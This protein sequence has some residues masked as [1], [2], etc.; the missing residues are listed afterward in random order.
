MNHNPYA[1]FYD[2]YQ[3]HYDHALKAIYLDAIQT[4]AKEGKILE[5]GCGPAFIG[6]ALA[7]LGYDVLATDIS[8]DFLSQAQKNATQAGCDLAVAAHNI[9]DPIPFDVDHVVMGFDV[10][11]HLETLDQFDQALRHIYAALPDGGMLFFDVLQCDYI[12]TMVGHVEALTTE[13]GTLEWRITQGPY[14]CSFRHRLKRDDRVITLN[15][16][17]F[18]AET[19]TTLL[20]RFTWVEH[21]PL[22][23]RTVYILKK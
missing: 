5:M 20:S 10:I 19:M 13:K 2:I 6:I 18:A 9:L 14:P 21:L 4:H 12:R 7:E 11:N 1:L 23:D 16:R 17:S 22:S 3:A 8:E 15:Q